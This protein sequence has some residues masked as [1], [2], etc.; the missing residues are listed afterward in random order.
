MIGFSI[1]IGNNRQQ[2]IKVHNM[3]CHT[4]VIS[5]DFIV[6]GKKVIY[7]GSHTKVSLAVTAFI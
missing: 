6:V 4:L 5:F 3:L 1:T 7:F 2:A